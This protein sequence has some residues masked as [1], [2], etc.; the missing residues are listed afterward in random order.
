MSRPKVSGIELFKVPVSDLRRAVT[1]WEQVYGG[2]VTHEFP[3]RDGSINCLYLK[4]PGLDC[5]VALVPSPEHAAGVAGFNLVDF[6]VTNRAA[7]ESWLVHLDRLGIQH[8][9]VFFG[10][11][12]WATRFKDPDG[13]EHQLYTLEGPGQDLSG[14]PGR[15]RPV[16]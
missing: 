3:N 1:W 2:R 12:G 8:T 5:P 11:T 14:Q 6:A 16:S 10:N 9:G 7:L 13:I 15:A 4:V